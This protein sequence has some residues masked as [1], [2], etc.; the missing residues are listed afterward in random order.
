MLQASHSELGTRKDSGNRI[1][2]LS[3]KSRRVGQV[4]RQRLYFSR[5]SLPPWVRNAARMPWTEIPF[6]NFPIKD[7][8]IEFTVNIALSGTVN[9]VSPSCVGLAY[10][11]PQTTQRILRHTLIFLV[12]I[13]PS[14]RPGKR[15]GAMPFTMIPCNLAHSVNDWCVS[16]GHQSGFIFII[17]YSSPEGEIGR[18]VYI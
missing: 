11:L 5:S 9:M 16:P 10:S 8:G 12:D 14:P 1:G 18:G 3:S 6:G 2:I 4:C 7:D 15:A 13:I 17:I